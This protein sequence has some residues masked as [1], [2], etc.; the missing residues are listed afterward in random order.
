MGAGVRSSRGGACLLRSTVVGWCIRLPVCVRHSQPAPPGVAASGSRRKRP[1]PHSE[2]SRLSG[3]LQPGTLATGGP[4]RLKVQD[5]EE[6]GTLASSCQWRLQ[7]WP[8]P[9]F[10]PAFRELDLC[11]AFRLGVRVSLSSPT[12]SPGP[13]PPGPGPA[14]SPSPASRTRLRRLGLRGFTSVSTVHWHPLALPVAG[15]R[16]YSE[17]VRV[18]SRP[19]VHLF[20]LLLPLALAVRRSGCL[21]VASHSPSI[22]RTPY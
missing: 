17:I 6:K 1:R 9:G 16:S 3:W 19:H 14:A 10:Q 5:D 18:G 22:V 11:T 8:G 15:V 13:S 12:R 20:N 2:S 7:S 21:Q 4:G